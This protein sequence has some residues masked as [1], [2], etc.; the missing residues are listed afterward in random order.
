MK[1]KSHFMKRLKYQYNYFK[2]PHEIVFHEEK[3]NLKEA[4]NV[5][6]NGDRENL[7]GLKIGLVRDL[8]DLPY[9]T[10]YIRYLDYN[11]FDYEYYNIFRSDWQEK[12]EKFD[13][14]IFRPCSYPWALDDAR[15][16]IY[17]LEKVLG[18]KVLPSFKELMFY[19]NKLYQYYILKELKAPVAPTFTSTDY[20]ESLAFIKKAEYPLISKI[21]TG[22]GSSGVRLIKSKNQAR[23]LVKR[24]FRRGAPTYWPFLRQKNYVYLQQYIENDGYDLR[25]IVFDKDNIFGYYR[26]PRD[27]DFRASG[28]GIVIKKALPEEAVKIALNIAERLNY[29]ILAVDFVKSVNDNNYYIIEASIFIQIITSTHLM[30]DG[31]PGKYRYNEETDSLEFIPGRYWMPELALNKFMESIE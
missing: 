2:K 7:V 13:I 10:K 17:F 4:D 27:N 18:K 14:I 31:V 1:F 28:S 16:K 30:E 9:Y 3:E 11:D 29:N 15:D 23:R 24:I 8:D 26:K 25:V 5:I 6:F 21:R 19:E 22:S 12:A 20:R